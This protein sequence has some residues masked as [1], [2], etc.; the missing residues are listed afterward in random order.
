M[1]LS[2]LGASILGNMLAS[3]GVIRADNGVHKAGQDFL[4]HL[5]L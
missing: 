4:C 5:I 2:T 1:L 3:E